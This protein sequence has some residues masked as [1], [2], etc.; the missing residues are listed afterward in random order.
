MSYIQLPDKIVN[1]VEQ[2]QLNLPKDQK[3]KDLLVH[4]PYIANLQDPILQ[5]RV[6][7]LL[8]NREDLQ[9]YL[10]ATE[11][12]NTTLDDSLELAV[13]HG[14]LNEGTKV[15]HLSELNDPKYKYFRQNNNP[16]DVVYKEKAKFDVQN[17]IIGNLLKEINKGKLP[18]NE[19]FKKTKTASDIK[20]LGIRER[21]DKLFESDTKKRDNLLNNRRD[22][23]DDDD[24]D[25]NFPAR[26]R[27]PPASPNIPRPPVMRD[28]FPD[29]YSNPFNV[30]LNNLE[31]EYQNRGLE[32]ESREPLLQLDTNL[33]EIFP[34][35]DEILEVGG[36][37]Y[38]GIESYNK[39][40]FFPYTGRIKQPDQAEI[41]T[42]IQFFNGGS[43]GADILLERLH[44]D[45]RIRGNEEF[46]SFLTSE[47]C[48][49]A[50]QR[51]NISIHVPTGD[52]F[53]NNQNTQES[54]YTFL[55][56]QQD[57]TKKD[58]PLDFSYD[59]DLND[60][61]TKHLPSINDYDEVKYGFLA[62]KNSKFLFNLFNKN[63]EINGR[64]KLP[65]KHT[66][67]SADDYALRTLQDRNWPYFVNGIIEFSQGL[68]D[69]NDIITSDPE[70]AN[71]LNNTRSNFEITKNLYNELLTT[72]GINLHEF[73]VNL[74]IEEKHKID[75]DLTNNGYFSWD[76]NEV[77]I[78]TQILVTYRDFFL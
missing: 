52:I 16:L 30:N 65:V 12:L 74:G 5:N 59:D 70:E 4:L 60:Y 56:N 40:Q 39:Q 67:I 45:G 75:T 68:F 41:E 46:V 44:T 32:I 66:T 6:E 31:Q 63:Q 49:D 34:D 19:Y 9:N 58:I 47:P 27:S 51:D 13:S 18:D 28:F 35:A 64:K 33:K 8:K 72:V 77:Y 1:K 21:F 22:D 78:Q 69:I 54:I 62:N 2:V 23:D 42:E 36:N 20:D 57:E 43:E 15:R 17:P 10:L 7:D 53:V 14:K 61:M 50:L 24:D 25:D 76:P 11:F 48:H 55:D 73:F 29:D 71:I 26:G 37:H 3:A 38:T